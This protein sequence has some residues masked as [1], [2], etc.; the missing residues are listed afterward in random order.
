[1]LLVVAAMPIHAADQGGARWIHGSWVNVRATA[2]VDASVIAHLPTNTEVRLRNEG[3]KVCE[4]AWGADEHGF[5]SCRF[6]GDKPLLLR[7]LN[8]PYAADG[9]TANPQ[10]SPA[11]A[12]WVAPSMAALFDAGEY[13]RSKMLSEK[14]RNLEG[15]ML[16]DGKCCNGDGKAPKLVRYPIPEFEAMKALLANGIVA[17][18]DLDPP[19]LTCHR[20]REAI[21]KRF[22]SRGGPEGRDAWSRE[23]YPGWENYPRVYPNVD[24]CRVDEAPGVA[25]PEAKPSYFRDAGEI[26]PGSADIERISAHFRIP[27]RGRVTGSPKWVWDYDNWHY[28]GAWDIGNYALTLEKPIFENVIG[29]TGLVKASRW[30][31]EISYVPRGPSGGCQEGLSNHL[32]GKDAL[33]GYPS[34]KDALVWFQS[35][36]PLPAKKVKIK[37]RRIEISKAAPDS[38]AQTVVVHEIDIDGDGVADLVQWDRGVVTPESRDYPLVTLRTIYVNID[39]EWYPFD[40]DRYGECT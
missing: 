16:E 26:L 20:M 18:A 29:R 37:S 32:R 2:A 30:R 4:V 27:E 21:A 1:M 19:L 28:S 40:S 13:F 12:F 10:Y 22:E 8:Y 38:Y 25:L 31:P 35:T 3:D 33:A 14:Q 9:N 23:Y 6:L 24:D 15:G 5:V 7:E 34:V 11:R 36:K 39:G 17:S